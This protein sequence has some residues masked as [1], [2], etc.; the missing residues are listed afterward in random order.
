MVAERTLLPTP[1]TLP[2]FVLSP[3]STPSN[4]PPGCN[5]PPDRLSLSL[6]PSLQIL[7]G[8]KPCASM[9]VDTLGPRARLASRR[10][11]SALVMAALSARVTDVWLRPSDFRLRIFFRRSESSRSHLGEFVGSFYY[12]FYFLSVFA[13]VYTCIRWMIARN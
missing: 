5:T 7:H 13:R 12:F 8:T 3:Y 2:S 1:P 9:P 6:F 10:W 11:N 4:A